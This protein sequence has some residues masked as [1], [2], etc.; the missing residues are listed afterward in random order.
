MLGEEHQDALATLGELEEEDVAGTLVRGVPGL[1]AADE[2]LHP[3]R[4]VTRRGGDFC[5]G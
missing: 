3:V 1:Q 5:A 4:L 2:A